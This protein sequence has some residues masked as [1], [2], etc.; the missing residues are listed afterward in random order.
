MDILAGDF[1]GLG[2]G[3]LGDWD[4]VGG[5]GVDF[6]D[7]GVGLE[8]LFVLFGEFRFEGY[9]VADWFVLGEGC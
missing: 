9:W 4:V 8:E 2:L 5:A 3:W 7:R 6:L 1:D